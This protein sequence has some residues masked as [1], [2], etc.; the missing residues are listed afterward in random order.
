[1]Q[2]DTFVI[3]SPKIFWD[4]KI[5]RRFDIGALDTQGNV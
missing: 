2:G 4:E 3:D 5:T 1:M